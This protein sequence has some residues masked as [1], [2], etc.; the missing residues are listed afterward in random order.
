MTTGAIVPAAFAQTSD[1]LNSITDGPETTRETT[2]Q[3]EDQS[4]QNRQSNSIDQDLTAAINEEIGSGEASEVASAA[5]S[6]SESTYKTKYKSKDGGSTTP[7]PGESTA[8]S[9]ST[10]DVSNTGTIEQEQSLSSPVQLNDNDFGDDQSRS[11][12]V[13]FDLGFEQFTEQTESAV[14]DIGTRAPIVIP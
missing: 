10:S 6:D 3:T 12:V 13:G 4:E 7:I 11:A 1:P 9:D 5:N 2:E 14:P 8:V